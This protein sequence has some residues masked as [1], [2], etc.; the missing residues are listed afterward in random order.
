MKPIRPILCVRKK[1]LQITVGS[2]MNIG[3][4]HLKADCFR[5][6]FV[7]QEFDLYFLIETIL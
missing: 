6:T 1:L 7:S 5:I 2:K 4:F 3:S